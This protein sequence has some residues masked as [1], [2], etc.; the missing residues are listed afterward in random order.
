MVVYDA[1]PSAFTQLTTTAE[2][3]Y[4]NSAAGDPEAAID[5]AAGVGSY[6]AT[7]LNTG[8]RTADMQAGNFYVK[9]MLWRSDATISTAI[10]A[11]SGQDRIDRLVLRFNRGAST[12]ATVVVP[13]II[14][15]TPSGSPAIPALTRTTTGI[16][17][18]PIA[19]WTSSAGGGLTGLIDERRFTNDNWHDMRP[20]LNSFVGTITGSPAPQYR[21]SNDLKYVEVSGYL[22]TPPTTGNYNGTSFFTIP[23]AYRPAN[24]NGNRIPICGCPQ[25][26]AS[27]YV[28]CIQPHND[29]TFTLQFS[30]SSL[31]QSTLCIDGRY[32]LQDSNGYIIA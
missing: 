14:T 1:R 12:A 25:A 23:Y 17:D 32:P 18:F 22:Q 13:T 7:T 20:L 15:G 19:F 9:G 6:F 27:S 21:F 8:G 31:V 30:P 10:P 16:W 5:G 28:P 3:E 24:Q 26:A 29:G 4:M 2:W 11:A